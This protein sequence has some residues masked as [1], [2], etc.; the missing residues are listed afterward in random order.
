M[1]RPL[2]FSALLALSTMSLAATARDAAAAEPV[3]AFARVVVEHAEVR[4]GPGAGYRTIETLERGQTVAVDR[5]GS[6]QFWLKLTLD[7][8]R[9]GWVVGEEVEV[10]AV[11]SGDPDSP[12]RPGIF[13]PPPLVSAHAGLALFGGVLGRNLLVKGNPNGATS[14]D[15][16]SGHFEIRPS[17]VLAP[18]ISIEPF[19]GFSRTGDGTFTIVGGMGILHLLPDLAVDPYV[20]VGGG[21]LWTA[22]NAD[23]LALGADHQFMGRAAAGLLFGLRGR[24]LVRIEASNIALYTQNRFSNLQSYLAG[25]GVYF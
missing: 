1:I 9:T 21:Y 10:F 2:A 3:E 23:S 8:G 16:G 25:L 14:Y 5:R 13:A 20:G 15:V 7:D 4:S 11:R 22:P 6:D 18:Q 17:W 24:I 12:S 19:L